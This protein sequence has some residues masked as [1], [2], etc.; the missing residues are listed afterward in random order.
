MPDDRRAWHRGGACL[1]N[2]QPV[3]A[4]GARPAHARHP[5]AAVP[6]VRG[7]HRLSDE[8]RP[9]RSGGGF[10]LF[11]LPPVGRRRRLSRSPGGKT[12]GYVRTCGAIRFAIAPYVLFANAAVSFARLR[13][14]QPPTS[15]ATPAHPRAF[16]RA[17]GEP[18]APRANGRARNTRRIG[19]QGVATV[20]DRKRFRRRP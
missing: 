6:G 14:L 3:T 2:R 13:H 1:F 5:C 12:C 8:T 18:A 16:I 9:Y 19:N 11:H 4:A 15:P 7:D 17:R 20:A 10:A